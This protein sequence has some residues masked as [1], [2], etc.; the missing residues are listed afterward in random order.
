MPLLE[1]RQ[2]RPQHGMLFA[3]PLRVALRAFELFA[4][5]FQRLFPLRPF[6]VLLFGQRR[7]SVAFR[8]GAFLLALQPFQFKP[9]H[10]NARIRPVGLLARPAQ[11]WSSET[12]SFSPDCCSWRSRSSS[13]SIAE[14]SRCSA[15]CSP[16]GRPARAPARLQLRRELAHFALQNQRTARLLASARQHPP[17]VA[18]AVGQQEV[19]VGMALGDVA[20]LIRSV[21]R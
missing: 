2:L 13:A 5:R 17:V 10:R 19:T 1:R 3:D 4:H 12:A 6:A 8:M 20:S 7:F 14:V 18:L 16:P 21:A 11:S 9:R 15:S